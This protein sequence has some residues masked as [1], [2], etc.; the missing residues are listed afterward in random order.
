[1]SI[2][3][4]AVTTPNLKNEVGGNVTTNVAVNLTKS[5]D[6]EKNINIIT[7]IHDSS[8]SKVGESN[9]SHTIST[10]NE[11]VKIDVTVN[12]PD[13]WK[14]GKGT[15]YTAK[16]YVKIDKVKY[17]HS[18]TFGYRYIEAKA[19]GFY[20]N[21][22]KTFLKGVCMHHD[23]GCIGA[24]ANSSAI[25]RQIDSMIDMG[26]NAIRLAHN[27]SSREFLN[28]CAEKGIL[29]IE[30][31]FDAW[32]CAKKVK[33][34]ARYFTQYKDDVIKRVIKRDRNNPAIIA[35]SVGNEI[36]R[37]SSSYTNDTAVSIA[38]DMYNLIHSLDD[39]RLVTMGED[40][41]TNTIAQ[42]VMAK[43]DMIGI[44]YG[45]DGEYAAVR[46]KFP[47]VCIY[48]SE[49][50]SALSSRG[51]YARDNTKLQCSSL[52]DDFVEWGDPAWR[53]LK[54]HMD[55]S[56]L[57][58]MFVWTGWDYLGEPTPF[59]KYPCKNSYFG[60][61]D[62]AGFKKD[63]YYLYKSRW[64]QN[65]MIHIVNRN[66]ND[67]TEGASYP[68][69]IYSNCYRV[70]L[71]ANGQSVGSKLQTEIGS[72][73][74]FSYNVPYKKGTIVANGYDNS[75][76]LVAQDIV[77]TSHDVNGLSLKPDKKEVD[78]ASDDFVFVTCDAIDSNNVLVP[79]ADNEVTFAV[80]GGTILG[81]D[82][83]DSTCTTNMRSNARKMFNGKVLAVVRHDGK[84]GDM[85]ITA[86]SGNMTKSI[87]VVKGSKTIKQNEPV[88][89]FIDATNPPD[90]FNETKVTITSITVAKTKTAYSV[91]E[92][93]SNDDIIVKVNYSN[94][95]SK[96]VTN[97]IVEPET[98][99]TTTEKNTDI[100]I[101]YIENDKQYTATVTIQVV[102]TLIYSL[103]MPKTFVAAN[104]D[105][106]DTGVQL[107]N[108]DRDFTIFLEFSG[109]ANNKNTRDTHC[110]MHC[111]QEISP[112]P[113]ISYSVWTDNY[114]ANLYDADSSGNFNIKYNDVNTHKL[115]IKKSKGNNIYTYC[116][117]GRLVNISASYFQTV[118]QTL[119]LGCYQTANGTKGRFWNGTIKQCKIWNKAFPDNEIIFL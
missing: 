13:L 105:Y 26:V 92:P 84:R 31:L 71:F 118:D 10:D 61:V 36:I 94:G 83:G 64:T 80:I 96:A 87:T 38:T 111:M 34:F 6:G 22:E 30:E 100:I 25:E 79:T 109:S 60:I 12:N 32:T 107:L 113:G 63:V 115:V 48:G 102:N 2:S 70:E 24:E 78:Y 103:P 47:N 28:L 68:V 62:T 59:N 33:D 117:D 52:D 73:Y 65:P 4:I 41:P 18:T 95:T 46:A 17:S 49:T 112:W 98:V 74:E 93:Y 45:D 20:L 23:L 89:E 99:D 29:L 88:A 66:W 56:Y 90:Y 35:W 19:D 108:E 77:Y 57:A 110:V 43:M 58:G 21:G 75:G 1:M 37:T 39:T 3:D 55:S 97:F 50:T 104:K 91:G 76:N 51:I 101:S 5:I 27:P 8:G 72:K 14:I 85:T 106:I 86:T 42:A 82:N 116:I 11:T 53:A 15:L 54:R 44:N 40:R 69:M 16:V 81:T 67:K 9:T 7:E 119:L 114:G